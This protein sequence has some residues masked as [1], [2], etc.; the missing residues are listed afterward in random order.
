LYAQEDD[1]ARS[2]RR[3]LDSALKKLNKSVRKAR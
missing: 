3:Q 1:L 2:A